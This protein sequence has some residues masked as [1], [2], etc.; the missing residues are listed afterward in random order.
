MINKENLEHYIVGGWPRDKLIEREPNDKDYVVVGETEKSMKKR[1]FKP[2]KATSFPVF[3]DENNNEWALARK[4]R[5]IDEG[6]NG[7]ETFTENVTLQ[8]DLKRRD[9]T[10]NSIAYDPRTEKYIEPEGVN[11]REDLKKGIIRPMTNAFKEDPVRILR[12][13]RF[14]ARLN[15]TVHQET[16]DLA[17]EMAH[18][19]KNVTSERIGKETIK[20]MKQAI[21]PGMYW[22]I[23]EGIGSLKYLSPILGGLTDVPAGAEEHH[24]ETLFDHMVFSCD[25]M[26]ELLGNKPIPLLMAFFHD[27]GKVKTPKEDLPHHPKHD[28]NA[29]E[30]VDQLVEDFKL[31]NE[32][33]TALHIAT[34]EHIRIRNVYPE[35]ENSMRPKKVIDLVDSLY[36]C[37]DD[38]PDY[39]NI[40]LDLIKADRRGRIPSQSFDTE[41]IRERMDLALDAI[42]KIGAKHSIEEVRDSKIED[43]DGETIGEIITQ[44]RVEYMKKQES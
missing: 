38:G 7:F 9:F 39:M 5:K 29:S 22:I 11:A 23:L 42:N 4:E 17:E 25:E 15:F 18:K 44:D 10:I 43:Y 33:Q 32:Y 3:L 8:E 14:A 16:M 40:M 34:R 35:T 28:I 13:A 2:I 1:G 6:Y 19:L 27:I 31:S 24:E 21:N 37:S 12:M 36:I 26:Y 30:P 41:P 20:A